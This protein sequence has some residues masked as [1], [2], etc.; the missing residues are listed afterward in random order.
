VTARE[1]QVAT[2]LEAIQCADAE[3]QARGVPAG[4]GHGLIAEGCRAVKRALEE[5]LIAFKKAPHDL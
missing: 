5:R 2:W 1:V 4:T 3:M